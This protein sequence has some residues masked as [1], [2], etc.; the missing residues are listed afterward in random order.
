MLEYQYKPLA[1]DIAY[2]ILRVSLQKS[3]DNEYMFT[4]ADYNKYKVVRNKEY[5]AVYQYD[6]TGKYIKTY[7][8]IQEAADFN[9]V[10]HGAI[11]HAIALKQ[12]LCNSYW[13]TDKLD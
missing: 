8:S 1:K 11:D 12:K 7:N 10:T 4:M 13:A 5:L 3:K 2:R 9:K 6:I